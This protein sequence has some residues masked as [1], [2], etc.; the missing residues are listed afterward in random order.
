MLI[1]PIFKNHRFL[2]KKAFHSDNLHQR[3]LFHGKKTPAKSLKQNKGR[4]LA[5]LLL[6]SE[7]GKTCSN[8]RVPLRRGGLIYY[9]TPAPQ[10]KKSEFTEYI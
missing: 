3:G 5:T 1:F 7:L 8:Q 2:I 9:Q 10:A 6:R 4:E